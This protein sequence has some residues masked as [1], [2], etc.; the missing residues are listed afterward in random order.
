MPPQPMCAVEI[1]TGKDFST[2]NMKMKLL[3]MLKMI[4]FAQLSV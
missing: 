1:L 3:Y 4:N 2:N